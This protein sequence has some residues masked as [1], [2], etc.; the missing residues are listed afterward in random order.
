MVPIVNRTERRYRF[1]G[2]PNF[3]HDGHCINFL[4]Y[5][6]EVYLYD[7]SF[8]VGPIRINAPLPLNDTNVAV[9][10]T[11]LAPFKAAYF[12][13]AIDYMLGSIHNGPDFLASRH[14]PNVLYVNG[15]TVRTSDIPENSN[16]VDG[17]TF[18]WG[19]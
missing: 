8:G 2:L 12:D 16:G 3:H 19:N 18:R 1:W 10:G 13:G 15:M 4:V 7:A 9:G 17:L 5:N 6:D 11:S 14:I